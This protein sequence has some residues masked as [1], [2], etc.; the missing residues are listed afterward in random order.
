MQ[1]GDA[2]LMGKPGSDRFASTNDPDQDHHDGHDQQ[3]VNEP[4]DGV[5]ADQTQQ[6][7]DEQD[8][9]NGIKHDNDPFLWRIECQVQTG[10]PRVSFV[11]KG[12]GARPRIWRGAFTD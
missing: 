10:T 2:R 6:P 1:R 7:Q 9:G 4:T 11:I 12:G 8:N 3:Y 5:C